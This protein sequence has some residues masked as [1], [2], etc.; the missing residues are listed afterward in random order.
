MDLSSG[1]ET[2]T[3]YTT[4]GGPALEQELSLP[5]AH[6]QT[7]SGCTLLLQLL[8]FKTHLVEAVE[9]LHIRKD[10]ET[11]SE[12]QISKL[13][14]EKQKL[15]WEKES[16]QHQIE[17]VSNQHTESLSNVK[18]Q[19]QAKIRNV[20]EE[21]GKFQVSAELK[22]KEINNLKEELRSLQLLKYNLEKKSNELEQKL[23]LQS[24]SK[25]SH[26]N[27]LGEVEKQFS[28]LS[29]KC[30][31]VKQAHEK[32]EQTVDEAMRINK[33]L[34]STNE[35]Q[36]VTIVSLKKA[37]EE[38]SNKL[39]KVEMTSIRHDK[40][41]SHTS[42][43]QYIQKLHQKL[44]META[45]NKKLREEN[46]AVRAEKQEVMRSL[47]HTQQ[48]LL[49]QTQTVNGIEL[50][51]HT[52]REQYQVLKQEH[53]VMRDKSK[54]M[55]DKVAQLMECHAA[56]KT[57]WAK[58]M[59]NSSQVFHLTE[60][61]S[62]SELPGSGSL[63]QL[64]FSQIKNTDCLEDAGPVTKL[65]TGGQ[66]AINLQ[67]QFQFKQ[68]LNT[69]NLLTC[70]L[71]TNSLFSPCSHC[72]TTGNDSSILSSESDPDVASDLMYATSPVTDVNF[73][74]S[75]VSC[76]SGTTSNSD[77][78][79]IN[80]S[81]GLLSKEK[82]EEGGAEERVKTAKHTSKTPETHILAQ[83]TT[84][85]TSKKSNIQQVIDCVGS[86]PP[87]AVY[88][89]SDNSSFSQKVIEKDTDS[90]HVNKEREIC[91]EGQLLHTLSF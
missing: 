69:S 77:H 58:E 31:M 50:E 72:G 7:E 5:S 4:V 16:L 43:E 66:E 9:E 46:V 74:I 6:C 63:Q 29:R 73:L 56:S 52:Q 12:G 59:R 27:Q 26:L 8:E 88:E 61:N 53:E 23:A 47:Q 80:T 48:L 82:N 85:W 20:E 54:A 32:L 83:T 28:A 51:L 41:H 87:Q 30:A 67:Q 10:A 91:R 2:A 42:K 33:K 84:D 55:E 57:S 86:E 38:V 25:D 70:P 35:K 44:N 1:S 24:R 21:K 40:T 37:L 18:K 11:L 81:V 75:K 79:S 19:F 62:S 89:P 49:S 22:D 60:L 68:P 34:T 13:V 15:E 39:I 14:L 76:V 17:T 36:E 3:P 64:A 71:I 45:M 90:S 65:V 78:K